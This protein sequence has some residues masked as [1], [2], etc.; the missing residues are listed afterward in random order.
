MIWDRALYDQMYRVPLWTTGVRNY[1]KVP[2]GHYHW[3]STRA[4]IARN[5]AAMQKLPG[6]AQVSDVAIVGGGFGWS[7]DVL[8]GLG[9]NAI[10]VDISPYVL[11][12]KDQSEEAEIRENLVKFG[13][14]PDNLPELVIG[15]DVVDPWAYWLRPEGKRA[16]ATVVDED[17][18][19]TT[20]RRNVKQTLGNNI[21]CIVSEFALDSYA[22]GDED[23][24]ALLAERCD[25]LRPNPACTVLHIIQPNV[26]DTFLNWKTAAQWRTFLDGLGFNDHW[27]V[28]M[29][30]SVL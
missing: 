22:A 24:P 17:L 4:M 29:K 26:N 11:A 15:N 18:S 25:D 30:G 2:Y 20:S 27:V 8:A 1:P 28:D 10:S 5:V 12:T 23:G 16:V 14:D 21:D 13:F 9:I 7:C 6:F 3:W 19:T